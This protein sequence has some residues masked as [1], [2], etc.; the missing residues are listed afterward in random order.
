MLN[1]KKIPNGNNLTI[2]Q[3]QPLELKIYKNKLIYKYNYKYNYKMTLQ[4]I[5][6]SEKSIA[7][8]GNT[9]QYKTMLSELGGKYNNRLKKEGEITPGWIF[10]KNKQSQVHEFIKSTIGQQNTPTALVSSEYL[11]ILL[12]LE[13]IEKV[14]KITHPS[15]VAHPSVSIGDVEDYEDHE[16]NNC[17]RP[18]LLR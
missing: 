6:Y 7:V 18:R 9:D 2:K 10:P 17:I 13:N 12:R 11:N 4:L 5:Q 14:L 3:N 1:W 8:F 15:V 16:E